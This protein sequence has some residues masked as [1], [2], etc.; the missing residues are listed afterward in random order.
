MES[1]KRVVDK[2]PHICNLQWTNTL[3]MCNASYSRRLHAE[4]SFIRILFDFQ[5]N[6]ATFSLIIYGSNLYAGM[7]TISRSP[8]CVCFL[9]CLRCLSPLHGTDNPSS[10]TAATQLLVFCLSCPLC[11]LPRIHWSQLGTAHLEPEWL[12]GRCMYACA[13]LFVYT[14]ERCSASSLRGVFWHIIW[15]LEALMQ[16]P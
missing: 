9:V 5:L 15:F 13:S 6:G 8:L 1:P 4:T 3:K 11:M 7:C 2:S 16:L 10:V 12:G 14:A